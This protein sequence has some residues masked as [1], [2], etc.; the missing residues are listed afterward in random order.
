MCGLA[1]LF[2]PGRRFHDELLGGISNDLYHRGPDSAGI[3]N[4]PGYALIFRRLS[5][6]DPTPVAD[7]P[8]DSSDGSC[9]LIF[10]GEIYN[11][12]ELRSALRDANVDLKTNGDTEAILEGYRLWG[13]DILQRL[14]GMYAFVLI[15]RREGYA[16]IARDPLG[17]KPLYA[18]RRGGLFAVASEM[19][20]LLRLVPA[21]PDDAALAE[22]LTFGWAAG[23]QSNLDGIERIPG[24]TVLHVPLGGGAPRERKF[25]DMLS[26]LHPEN[27]SPDEVLEEAQA[28]LESSIKAHLASDVGYTAQ[29]SGGVDSSLV[30]AITANNTSKSLASYGVKLE[31]AAYDEGE[32][33][34][35]VVD[36]YGLEHREIALS[37]LDFADALPSAVRHMEGPVPHGGCVM[38]KLLCREARAKSKVILTGE[39][40][41]EMFGGYLRYAIWPRLK[42]QE[43][44]A[45]IVPPTRLPPMWPFLNIRRIGRRD[46]AVFASVYHDLETMHRTFPGL[47]PNLAAREG[48]SRRFQDFRDRLFAVDQTAYLESLL[49]RQD[50]MSMS[51]SVEARVPFVHLPL[52]KVVNRLPRD[53]RAPGGIT[54]PLLKKIADKLLPAE[55]VH[56]RKVGLRLPYEDWIADDG[57]LGR[58]LPLL[59]E[60][61]CRLAQYSAPGALSDAVESFRRGQRVGIPSLFGL[62]NVEL[63]LRGLSEIPEPGV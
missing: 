26:T 1:A 6:L 9:T 7:Q 28:A 43:K 48:V 14:E 49:V 31:D 23:A 3:A 54:K 40:A 5:I 56:R 57:A 33:R 44:V 29:L 18:A 19:R 4:E 60:P 52:L 37:G 20:P 27:D 35:M 63:W 36:Q 12:G 17:I 55:L 15:D 61:S 8:M 34:Q 10:N 16:L 22:L 2:E 39:G 21:K 41:D 45:Q 11:Y 32:Y 30:A 58:Y 53:I 24:G 13:Q 59:T 62:I 25:F 51:E 42:W 50:K 46:A 38:L 47:V